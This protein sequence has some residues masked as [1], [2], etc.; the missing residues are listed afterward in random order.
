MGQR[1]RFV[2]IRRRRASSAPPTA[3]AA[4]PSVEEP[5]TGAPAN[6]SQIPMGSAGLREIAKLLWTSDYKPL[7]W[8]EHEQNLK[9]AGGFAANYVS[10]SAPGRGCSTI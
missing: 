8:L 10:C 4:E 5:I 6:T 2:P 9:T 7:F 3:Q 1:D